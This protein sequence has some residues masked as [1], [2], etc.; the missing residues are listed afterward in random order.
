MERSVLYV[1]I[2]VLVVGIG[3]GGYAWYD[4]KRDTVLELNVGQ[5]G[6]SVQKN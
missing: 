6:I 2:A 5:S 4:H 3:V 1:I